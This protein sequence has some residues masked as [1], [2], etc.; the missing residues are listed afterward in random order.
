[1]HSICVLLVS[2]VVQNKQ[3]LRFKAV[4]HP[5]SGRKQSEHSSESSSLFTVSADRPR[6]GVDMDI[7]YHYRIWFLQLRDVAL[8]L[9]FVL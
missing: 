9:G 4:Q 3:K 8:K 5:F 6:T 2:T 1:M 7:E